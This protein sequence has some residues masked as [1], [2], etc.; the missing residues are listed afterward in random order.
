MAGAISYAHRMRSLVEDLRFGGLPDSFSITISIGV[1]RYE[2]GES[3]ESLL[4]RA[5]VALYS[6]KAQGRNCVAA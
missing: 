5:D 1:A 6:A 4:A 2:P 3:I